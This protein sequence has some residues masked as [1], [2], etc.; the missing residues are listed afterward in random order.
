V[1]QNVGATMTASLPGGAGQVATVV[2]S[3]EITDLAV[4][5]LASTPSHHLTLRP[6]PARLGELCVALGS[7]LGIYPESASLGMVSGL[8]RTIPQ[9]GKRPIERAIQ[10]DCAINPG[11][12]GG[13]LVDVHGEVLGVNKCIDDRGA[14]L[15]FAIPADTI[16]SVAAAL[17]ASGR[18]DR[19][20]IGV[21]VANQSVEV[22]GQHVM[23][24]VVTK[25]RTTGSPL[26]VGDVILSVEG[27]VCDERIDLLNH[28]MADHIGKNL[29]LEV[30]REGKVQPLAVPATKLE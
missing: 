13:P 21:T 5:R 8:A 1:V 9:P 30:L 28:L 24:L 11:N 22:D 29:A 26:A 27:E 3:D 16:G 15:G 23:R 20:S 7:P 19:A 10:T 2:G 14:G 25:V 4:L 12:S 6:E 17:I 18:V